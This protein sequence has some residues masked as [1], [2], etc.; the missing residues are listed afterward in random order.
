MLALLHRDDHLVAIHKPA[1]LLVHRSA[2][3]ARETRFAVQLLRDQLGRHVFPVHR[4]DKGTSGVLLFALDR[5]TLA[6]L[7]GAFEA[8]AVG[9]RYVAVVRG[10][11]PA[12]GLID[13]PLSRRHDEAEHLPAGIAGTPRPARTRFRTL[14]TAELPCRVDRYPTSRYALAELVPET[15]RRHQLRRH[16]KHISHP[17]VGD[18]TF[19][20]GRHNRLFQTLFGVHRLL[21]ACTLLTFEHPWSGS[22]VRIATA[23]DTDFMQAVDALG[24]REALQRSLSGVIDS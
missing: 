10:H 15:G 19:G 17:I 13:H 6:R 21:L 20:K 5:E 14:A 23:P 8:G 16:L 12:E 24:W 2:L 9:K 22:P 11:P 18:A 7:S 4:L 3:D 1:G